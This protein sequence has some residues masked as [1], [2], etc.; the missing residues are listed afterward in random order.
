MV[1]R[2]LV[3]NEIKN[4]PEDLLQN[5]KT[6][7]RM[8][9]ESSISGSAYAQSKNEFYHLTNPRDYTYQ[10]QL[11][12]LDSVSKADIQHFLENIRSNTQH[13]YLVYG[14]TE[15]VYSK[16]FFDVFQDGTN[17]FLDIPQSYNLTR[18]RIPVGWNIRTIVNQNDID[19]NSVSDVYFE[20]GP[21]SDTRLKV[22]ADIISSP[23]HQAAFDQLRSKE[24]LGYIVT[25]YTSAFGGPIRYHRLVVVGEKSDATYF[26]ERI[27]AFLQQY[28]DERVQT[29]S[30][31]D[32]Q[33][34][35]DTAKTL[36]LRSDMSLAEK[37]DEFWSQISWTEYDWERRQKLA[38]AVDSI[39]KADVVNYYRDVFLGHSMTRR[40]ILA[41]QLF[42]QNRDVTTPSFEHNDVTAQF[43]STGEK[44][45]H[46]IQVRSE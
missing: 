37:K 29:W 43:L 40:R 1:V 39:T 24:T 33:A 32:F 30:D 2:L 17:A 27:R 45:Q 9:L 13:E 23:L 16:S 7:M 42:A 18:F 41:V 25:Q 8:S 22:M 20:I 6:Q 46:E 5:L 10:Q 44:I 28:Y 3:G 31:E 38:K 34:L 19:T 14:N 26:L 36:Y 12:V 21:T 4:L 15:N 35:K 11:A